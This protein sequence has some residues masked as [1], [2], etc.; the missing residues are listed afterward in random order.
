MESYCLPDGTPAYTQLTPVQLVNKNGD[1]TDAKVPY[2]PYESQVTDDDEYEQQDYEQDTEYQE[3]LNKLQG[4]FKGL[5]RE[6]FVNRLLLNEASCEVTLDKYRSVLFEELKESEEFPFGLQCELKRR[7]HTRNGDT[8]PVKLAYDVHSLMSVIEGGDYSDLKDMLR[9]N[10]CKTSSQRQR[11]QSTSGLNN[12]TMNLCEYSVDIKELSQNMSTVKAEILT[13]KQKIVAVE[14]TRSSE[15]QTLK[16]TV[17]TLKSDLTMLSSTVTKAV[18]EIKL[19]VE[20]L[21]SA[22]S[23]G[24]ANLKNEL[25]LVKQTVN[26]LQD[27]V[28]LLGSSSSPH[29]RSTSVRGQSSTKKSGREREQV[30]PKT[31]GATNVESTSADLLNSSKHNVGILSANECSNITSP[32]GLIHGNQNAS[33]FSLHSGFQGVHENSYVEL[34]DSDKSYCSAEIVNQSTPTNN[35]NI[36][37]NLSSS[38]ISSTDTPRSPQTS[39]NNT[40][41]GA[42]VSTASAVATSPL[43]TCVQTSLYSEVTNTTA[44]RVSLNATS[45]TIMQT[46]SGSAVPTVC[47]LDQGLKHGQTVS[48]ANGENYVNRIQPS[49]Q[50]DGIIRRIRPSGAQSNSSSIEYTAERSYNSEV[51]QSYVASSGNH[52][53]HSA[54]NIPV[55]ITDMTNRSGSGAN[56]SFA[57]TADALE[58]AIYDDDD[59]LQYVKKKPKRFYLGGFKPG[60]TP[61]LIR[62]FV[63]K[64]GPSVTWVRIWHS[65]RNPNSV[66]IRLN[67]E[68]NNYAECITSPNFWPRGVV[69]RPWVNKSGNMSGRRD[70]SRFLYE[71]QMY[72]RSDVDEYNPWSPLRD[73]TNLD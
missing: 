24:V 11:S 66:V 54:S 18:T 33:Q 16:S 57:E 69:C 51:Q 59:F 23:L 10:S 60:V 32:N 6:M 12:S 47:R 53:S 68:D 17:L 25:R 71:R 46:L 30:T 58:S 27:T 62:N 63:S 48:N 72:G 37:D 5:P 73:D 21:E 19:T 56:L 4:L 26:D 39:L 38:N 45:G 65:R 52:T 42:P 64:R 36:C 61:D 13:L 14:S 67:I 40:A 2:E 3:V 29:R 44:G 31:S 55:L 7:V 8:V 43:D 1:L 9:S 41:S 28:E 50:E 15:L 49:R 22:K 20:R 34:S 70:A 35:T